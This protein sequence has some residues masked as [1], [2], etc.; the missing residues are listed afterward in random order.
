M[1]E[2][3]FKILGT[4]AVILAGVAAKKAT[5]VGWKAVMASDAPDKPEESEQPMLEIILFGAVSGAI[6]A[7]AKG[8]A[9]RRVNSYMAQSTGSELADA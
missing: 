4:L 6:M 5:D 8:L 7:L 2:K 9:G 3:V 1:N